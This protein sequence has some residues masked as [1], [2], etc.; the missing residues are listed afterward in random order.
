M[1]GWLQHDLA[2]AHPNLGQRPVDAHLV[3]RADVSDSAFGGD[4]DQA[5][6]GCCFA[7]I[8]VNASRGQLQFIG[9][10]RFELRLLVK[11]QADATAPERRQS[12]VTQCGD[13]LASHQPGVGV[14]RNFFASLPGDHRAGESFDLRQLHCGCGISPRLTKDEGGQGDRE[15]GR[16]GPGPA[17]PGT[18]MRVDFLSPGGMDG[19]MDGCGVFGGRTLAHRR[20]PE[21]FLQCIGV[22][23]VGLVVSVHVVLG[24]PAVAS[25]TGVDSEP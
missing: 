6:P 22:G 1:T 9:G 23:R 4:D 19:C 25:S 17:C 20:D 12:R 7:G 13:H 2:F 10:D 3:T 16:S 24:S 8:Y 18:A 11:T 14:Q 5:G 15:N 21:Q